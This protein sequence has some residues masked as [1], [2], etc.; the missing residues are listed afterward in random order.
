MGR[1]I[2]IHCIGYARTGGY[3]NEKGEGVT[4]HRLFYAMNRLEVEQ[5]RYEAAKEGLKINYWV[6]QT[7]T[8]LRIL[9]SKKVFVEYW[10][11]NDKDVPRVNTVTCPICL[12]EGH[13][14][15]YYCPV[16]NGSGITK[17]GNEK[18]WQPWQI[19][20]MKAERQNVAV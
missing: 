10:P 8:G 13:N 19:E 16:C 12:G 17:K 7:K 5:K 18:R 20:H 4:Q 1:S 9:A 6:A 2:T 14:G 15:K 3:V 11:I